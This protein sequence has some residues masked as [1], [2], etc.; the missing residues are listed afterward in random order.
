MLPL[1]VPVAVLAS[2]ICPPST[3]PPL[4]SNAFVTDSTPV[5]DPKDPATCNVFAILSLMAQEDEVRQ[6]EERYRAGNM[7]YGE[8]KKRVHELFEETFGAARERRAELVKDPDYVE[9]V[10]V[11]GV[12]K[13]RAVARPLMEQVRQACGLVTAERGKGC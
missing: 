5:E 8:V 1:I 3:I 9:D 11:A 12:K 2:S 4:Q 13:A 7:G 6:W 10:L